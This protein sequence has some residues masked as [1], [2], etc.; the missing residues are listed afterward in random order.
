MDFL[1]FKEHKV[2]FG[3]TENQDQS[4][5][6]DYGHINMSFFL[7]MSGVGIYEKDD[8]FIIELLSIL[9]MRIIPMNRCS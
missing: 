9:F 5:R 3:V 8:R 7:T 2:D 1:S 4:I 6:K